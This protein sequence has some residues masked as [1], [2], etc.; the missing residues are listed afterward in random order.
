MRLTPIVDNCDLFWWAIKLKSTMC[1]Q[2]VYPRSCFTCSLFQSHNFLFVVV[3][4][5]CFST[6]VLVV[7]Y[8]TWHWF[9]RTTIL[10]THFF[11]IHHLR[12]IMCYSKH[13]KH[14]IHCSIKCQSLLRSH[15][16]LFSQSIIH[17]CCCCFS[18][19]MKARIR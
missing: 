4:A 16:V 19:N 3:F 15:Q 11:T 10:A 14:F 6:L 18:V 12:N 7:A 9:A 2:C 5:V 8:S 17:G 1:N 13:E